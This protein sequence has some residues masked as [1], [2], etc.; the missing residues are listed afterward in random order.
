MK[1]IL[2]VEDEADLRE[3]LVSVL[4]EK[5]DV[6]AVTTGEE[7]L[8]KVQERK[9]DLILLDIMTPGMHGAIFLQRLRALPSGS[10][11]SQVL[12]LTNLDN[13]VT[14]DKVAKFNIEAFLVKANTPL[15]SVVRI[16]DVCLG[17]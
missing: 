9:P 12:I 2:L 10:N 1:H 16:V 3:A 4:G 7:A 8:Q 15:H 17:Q 5:Y 13:D 6:T 11:D 14:R